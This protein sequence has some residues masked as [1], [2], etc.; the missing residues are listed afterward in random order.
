MSKEYKP[1]IKVIETEGA[2]VRVYAGQRTE[3]ERKA[4]I[5]RAVQRLYMSQRK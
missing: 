1:P 5:E 4:A 2:I 3:A